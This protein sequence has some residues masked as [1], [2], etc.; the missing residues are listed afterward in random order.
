MARVLAHCGSLV[1][2]LPFHLIPEINLKNPTLGQKLLRLMATAGVSRLKI[3]AV[4]CEDFKMLQPERVKVYLPIFLEIL[5]LPQFQSLDQDDLDLLCKHVRFTTLKS[6]RLFAKKTKMTHLLLVINGGL[7]RKSSKEGKIFKAT[8]VGEFA[9]SSVLLDMVILDRLPRLKR[10]SG[11][12]P[13]ACCEFDWRRR[14]QLVAHFPPRAV[15]F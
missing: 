4:K 11:P 8:G 13:P 7:H 5:Q 12:H 3:Q 10:V 15:N 1:A 9:A 14:W 6:A 2:C